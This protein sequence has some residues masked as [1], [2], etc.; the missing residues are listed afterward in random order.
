MR[1]AKRRSG[2]PQTPSP[3]D[4][5]THPRNLT[6]CG[7]HGEH[8]TIGVLEAEGRGDLVLILQQQT[9]LFAARLSMQLD[10]DGRQQGGCLVEGCEVGV[11]GE[12]R[13][14][15]RD[16]VQHVDVAE[17]TVALLQVRFK[18]EG[19]VPCNGPSLFHLPLEHW[20]VFGTEAVPP[21][22]AGRGDER[23]RHLRLTPDQPGVE[24]SQRGAHVFSGDGENLGGPADRV[25]EVHALVPDGIPDGI[26][27]RFDVAI[28]LVDEDHVQVAV[29]AQRASS[30]AP[31]GHEGEV[32]AVVP[33]GLFGQA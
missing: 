26:G 20:Q 10:T 7:R 9:V 2:V 32:A 22:G 3:P 33:G 1:S 8:E 11:V 6:T 30:I 24:Q 28:A 17:A 16:G 15:R 13:R 25:V 27:D 19:D 23:F 12:Q 29:R 4:V 14:E 21:R 5:V 31:D 18:Q